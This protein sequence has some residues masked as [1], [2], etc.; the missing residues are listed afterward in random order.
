M[1]V[2]WK[3]SG[4]VDTRL[5]IHIRS[6]LEYKIPDC[7]RLVKEALIGGSKELH[8]AIDSLDDITRNFKNKERRAC[9]L[10]NELGK[11]CIEVCTLMEEYLQHLSTKWLEYIE[12]IA[13]D[14]DVL[15]KKYKN[16]FNNVVHIGERYKHVNSAL[17]QRE[18]HSEVKRL[19]NDLEKRLEELRH[20]SE[21]NDARPEHFIRA[22]DNLR[23][24]FID[25]YGEIP[26]Q[27][28]INCRIN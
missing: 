12:K 19:E 10:D 28:L 11:E 24:R 13:Q 17:V 4:V 9:T 27:S 20:R 22:C 7:S 18:V 6:S 2:K 26:T 21:P 8:T 16:M 15:S 1:V 23:Q 14:R 3:M 5:H 25:S